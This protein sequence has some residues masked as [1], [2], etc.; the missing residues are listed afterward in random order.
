[1]QKLSPWEVGIPTYHFEAC[2]T[3]GVSSSMAL[4]RIFFPSMLYVKKSFGL[5]VILTWRMCIAVT[6]LLKD[7]LPPFKRVLLFCSF[8]LV[9]ESDFIVSLCFF[10]IYVCI[11]SS[12]HKYES[13]VSRRSALYLSLCACP[14]Q[15]EGIRS[16]VSK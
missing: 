12:S 2:K 1:M 10:H 11:I 14:R 5:F 6:S 13:V 16:W 15:G 7:K 4:F 9:I 8:T 3:V